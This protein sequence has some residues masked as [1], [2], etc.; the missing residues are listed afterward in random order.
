MYSHSFLTLINQP[1][2]IT[3]H[4]ATSIDNIFSSCYIHDNQDHALNGLFFVD[5]SDHLPIFS[6]IPKQFWA[7]D[8]PV[9]I[10]KRLQL[11]PL[12]LQDSWYQSKTNLSCIRNFYVIQITLMK[13]STKILK[14][15]LL[16]C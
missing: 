5:V 2:R 7:E 11:T 15:S 3:S 4:T 14:T 8:I 10:T 13:Q 16:S 6:I 1:T 12:T 9:K